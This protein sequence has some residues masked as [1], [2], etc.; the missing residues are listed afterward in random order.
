MYKNVWSLMCCFFLLIGFSQAKTDFFKKFKNDYRILDQDLLNNVGEI[1]TIKDFVYKKDVATFTFKEGTIHLLRYVNDR[2]TT[3]I[4]IG[5]GNATIDIPTHEGRQGMLYSARDSVVNEDFTVLFIRMA[6]DFDLKLKEKFTFTEKKLDWKMFQPAKEAQG[7]LFF[8]PSL[9]HTYD[10]YFQMMRSLYERSEDGYFWADFNRYVFSFDPNRPEEVEVGY[11]REGGDVFLT[12]GA[13]FQRQEKQKYDDAELSDISYPTTIVDKTGDFY[14]AGLDGRK[15]E[16]GE[17]TVSIIINA[18][19]LR[20]LSLFLHYNMKIDSIYYNNQQVEYW[21]RRNFNFFGVILPEYRYKDDT[22]KL[23]VWYNG[24]HFDTFLPYV[25]NPSPCP[26]KLHF[27]VPKGYN[28]YMPGMGEIT[29]ADRGNVQFTVE[30]PSNM[31]NK[32]FF[33]VYATRVDTIQVPSDI[34]ITLNFIKSHNIRKRD[35]CFIPYDVYRSSITDAF[36]YFTG[37]LGGPINT[38]SE[39]VIPEGFMSMPGIIQVPQL[40]CVRDDP[41]AA[42]GGLDAISGISVAKQWFGS[43]MRPVSYREDWTTLALPNF[44]C[45]LF[46]ENRPDGNFYYTNLLARQDSLYTIEELK[47]ELPLGVGRRTDVTTLTNKGVWLLHMLRFLMYDYETGSEKSFMRFLHELSLYVNNKSFSNSDFFTIAEKYYGKPL[48]WFANEWLYG[49]GI[50]KFDVIYSIKKQDGKYVIP[51]D[52]KATRVR[53]DFTMPVILRV[54]LPGDN[55][56]FLRQTVNAGDTHFELGP[57]DQKPSELVF[58][59]FYSVLSRDRV[60]KK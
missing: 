44:M 26:V 4:F 32:F 40:A 1:A 10:N 51:V 19:S 56:V 34:G 2:P 25:E 38:F 59:E 11:E 21:R 12:I 29:K 14:I 24:K 28:Y 16:K 8:K 13:A 22:V 49:C 45:L 9:Y 27:T 58:N 47:R 48:D 50:P 46:I 60:K 7:E 17:V 55:Y 35:E 36:N 23:T 42:F 37:I 31:Y 39:Y 41:F 33:H 5:A 20:Y 6:D 18:D 54:V 30:S 53:P 3:A 43:L 52:V 15:I 57:F